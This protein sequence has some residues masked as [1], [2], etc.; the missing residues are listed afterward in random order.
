MNIRQY[1]YKYCPHHTRTHTHTHTPSSPT[2]PRTPTRSTL[3]DDD[4]EE[5]EEEEEVIITAS[6]GQA[7]ELRSLMFGKDSDHP[8]L[9]IT[10]SQLRRTRSRR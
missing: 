4:D 1:N 7:R 10:D 8:L 2:T 5:E 3:A 9:H 6:P